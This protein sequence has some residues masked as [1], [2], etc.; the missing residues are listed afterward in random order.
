LTD[1]E[2]RSKNSLPTRRQAARATTANATTPYKRSPNNNARLGSC[3]SRRWASAHSDSPLRPTAAATGLC[4]PISN[5]TA[6]VI[7]ANAAR[8]RRVRAF[9]KVAVTCGVLIRLNWVPSR[10]TRRQPRQNAARCWR[11]VARGRN[12]RRINSVKISHGSRSRRSDH[13]LSASGVRNNWKRCAAN[14]PA[15]CIT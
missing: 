5:R 12:A 15:S 6:V 4:S 11:G 2:A 3:A 10:P 8:P 7:L 14:V 9:V 1:R 13:E